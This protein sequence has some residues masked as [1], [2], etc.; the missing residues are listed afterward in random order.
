MCAITLRVL[1]TGYH[2]ET[3]DL[4]DRG[5]ERDSNLPMCHVRR[6][7]G[8]EAT[9]W[10]LVKRTSRNGIVG[11]YNVGQFIPHFHGFRRAPETNGK[12]LSTSRIDLTLLSFAEAG[13]AN[14][15]A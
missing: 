12:K 6:I 14:A 9:V 11:W 3:W 1:I 4:M 2:N 5:Q 10:R 13:H 8:D 15:Y 7:V